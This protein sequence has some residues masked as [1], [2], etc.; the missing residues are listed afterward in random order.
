MS[1]MALSSTNPRKGA[2]PVPGPTSTRGIDGGGGG[3]EPLQNHAG[4]YTPVHSN[5]SYRITGDMDRSIGKFQLHF[6]I[7]IPSCGSSPASHVEQRPVRFLLKG[8]VHETTFTV[9]WT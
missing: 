2:Q 8:V 3:R 5:K 1:C 9:K 7:P 4:I 6:S